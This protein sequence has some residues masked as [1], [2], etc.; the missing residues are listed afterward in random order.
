MRLQLISIKQLIRHMHYYWPAPTIAPLSINET[1]T[2]EKRICL[3]EI[4]I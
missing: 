3:S 2:G 1:V 4:Y